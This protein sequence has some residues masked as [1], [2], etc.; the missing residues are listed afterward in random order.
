M[1]KDAMQLQNRID[2]GKNIL[3]AE[4]TPPKGGHPEPVRTAAKAFAGKVH[5]LGISDNRDGVHMSALAA[6][7]IAAGEG[8]EPI[9]H[10]V[11]RDSNRVALI[12][13]SLGAQALGVQNILCT[14]GTHQT[15]G[16]FKAAKNV[17]DIDSVQLLQTIGGLETNGAIVGEDGFEEAGPFCL[18]AVAAPFA[19]PMEMQL[20]RLAKKVAAGAKYLVTQPVFDL[21]RFAVWWDEVKSRGI[22]GNAAV[23]AGIRPLLNADEATAYAQ[24]RPTPLIPDDVLARVTSAGD[25]AAQRAAGIALAVETIKHLTDAGVRGL[26]ICVDGDTEA[27]LE[28]IEKSGLEI[29]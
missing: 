18:G 25:A 28:I 5:A 11:T 10:M 14:S 21:D 16:N 22:N 29:D 7:S 12:S 15:L 23:V 24:K 2:S 26:E 9:L 17:F 8:V 6:A 3:I 1:T 27:A 4:I 19:D 13:Q 20:I